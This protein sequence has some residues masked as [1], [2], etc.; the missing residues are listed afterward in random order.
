M[1]SSALIF[2]LVIGLSLISL[3]VA[4]WLSRKNGRLEAE[5]DDATA[6]LEGI[7]QVQ[8]IRDRIDSDPDYAQRVHDKFTRE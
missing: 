6:S 8:H 2:L 4:I 5:R 7:N 3:G 1:P